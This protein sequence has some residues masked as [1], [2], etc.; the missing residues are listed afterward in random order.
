[1]TAETRGPRTLDGK[2]TARQIRDEV[3]RGCA[4]LKRDR[5]IVPGLTVVLVGDDPASEV[6]VRNKE[7]AAAKAGM[8]SR[9]ERLPAATSEARLLDL[10]DRLNVDPQVHGV[11]VQLPLPGEIDTQRVIQ[12]I[13][14]AKD[15]DG[16][17]P[18]NAG[19]LLA[20]LPGF[21][22]CTPAGVIELLK[23]H[24]IPLAGRHAVVIGRSNIVGKPMALLLLREN[25]T[26][27]VCHSRTRELA[28][29]AAR[30]EILVAAVGRV[31]LV[32]AEF[33]RPGAAVVDVGIHRVTDEDE[34]RRLFGDD[35]ARLAA[36][37][38]KGL[39]LAGDV[40]PLDAAARAAWLTPV[41]GGVGP[42]TIAMLLRNTLES[43]RSAT[44]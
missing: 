17:H 21:V 32:T 28:E 2:R 3:A 37:R 30:G 9:I 41:P 31:G 42:L 39:T 26:V 27:T 4:A 23:R 44:V 38:E 5:G 1:M 18:E 24:D 36:V 40:N 10:V 20:G 6:Y 12:A 29:V 8:S 11:L 15:V 22:P 19:R 34:V 13:D 35:A 16:L 14:P 7:L 43:A 33:I 25:C